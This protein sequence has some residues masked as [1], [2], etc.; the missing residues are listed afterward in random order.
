MLPT[1][2]WVDLPTVEI[3]KQAAELCYGEIPVKEDLLEPPPELNMFDASAE[4]AD[5]WQFMWSADRALRLVPDL[6]HSR[7]TLRR[8][9][10]SAN[11]TVHDGDEDFMFLVSWVFP[12][13]SEFEMAGSRKHALVGY[14]TGHYP[15]NVVA[16]LQC[17]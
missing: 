6:P 5:P 15:T 8:L 17:V 10:S 11:A 2:H 4:C 9:L 3:I 12:D 1:D 14:Y 13:A 16:T 7:Q